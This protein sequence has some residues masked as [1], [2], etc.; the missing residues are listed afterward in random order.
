M[1]NQYSKHKRMHHPLLLLLSIVGGLYAGRLWLQDRRTAAAGRP[2]PGALPGAT[3]APVR[4]VVIA[5]AGALALLAA[6]TAGE[7]GLGVAA[8]QARITW[9]FAV[10]SVAAAPIIEE[11]IFRGWLVVEKGGRSLQWTAAA[12]ASVAFALLHPFLWRWDDAGF[13]WTAGLKGWFSTLVVFL[14]SLWLYA[15][16]LASWN[17]RH[18]LLPCFAAHSAKNLGVVAIKAA[19]GYATGWW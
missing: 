15:A 1:T 2:A 14:M 5:V 7:I 19:T 3:P 8:E 6:E 4:A 10:Y 18:S 12:G 9:L 11:L 17:P 13:A 16:R